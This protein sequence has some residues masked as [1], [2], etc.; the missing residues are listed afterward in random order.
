MAK[1]STPAPSP[2][3]MTT[4]AAARIQSAEARIHDGKV[5]SGGVATR[6]SAQRRRQQVIATLARASLSLGQWNN[7][8]L[9]Q[10]QKHR[11]FCNDAQAWR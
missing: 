4:P 8:A 9:Q 3:R 1:K 10:R 7:D 2:K 5:Q 11:Q 6:R